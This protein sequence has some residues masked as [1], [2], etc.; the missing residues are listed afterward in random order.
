MSVVAAV[1]TFIDPKEQYP[2]GHRINAW[3]ASMAAEFKA[4]AATFSKYP[5]KNIG[6]EQ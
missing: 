1:E 3:L 4:H 6:L 5:E 2:V